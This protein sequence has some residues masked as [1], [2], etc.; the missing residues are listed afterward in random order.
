MHAC[1][2]ILSAEDFTAAWPSRRSW[3]LRLAEKVNDPAA[4]SRGIIRSSVLKVNWTTIHIQRSRVEK[5][6]FLKRFS[7]A[8]RRSTFDSRIAPWSEAYR[9]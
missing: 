5:T 9:K 4:R 3:L 8:E 2:V 7:G 1:G 6:T